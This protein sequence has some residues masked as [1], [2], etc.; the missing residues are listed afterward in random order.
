VLV[1]HFYDASSAGA[2]I[3]ISGHAFRKRATRAGIVPQ[4]WPHNR[5]KYT[6]EQVA[7]VDALGKPPAGNRKG[8][9]HRRTIA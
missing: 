7:V 8:V 1:T 3:G 2:A 9:A 5:K 4:D 6:P